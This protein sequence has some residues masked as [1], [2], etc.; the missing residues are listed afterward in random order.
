MMKERRKHFL[1]NKPLQFRYMA[2]LTFSLVLI[3]ALIL[4]ALYVSIWTS[5]ADAFSDASL[6][7]DMLTA[8]RI[9]QYEEARFPTPQPWADLSFTNQIR[10]LSARQR[11]VFKTILDD[12]NRKLAIKLSLLFFFIAWGSIFLSHK[13]AGPLLRFHATLKD[14]RDGEL[15][16]RITLRKF[17]E[18]RFV[19][20][21][22]N[23]TL[24]HYDRLF[25]RLKKLLRDHRAQSGALGNELEKELSAFKTSSE[26]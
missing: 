13:I 9:S 16:R 10:K 15:S 5:I 7:Q 17:D 19:A 23:A 25:I 18:A 24:D 14:F 21:D 1:I 22:F 20:E 11:E 12:S 26:K 6:R 4:F 2:I 8:A 3:S